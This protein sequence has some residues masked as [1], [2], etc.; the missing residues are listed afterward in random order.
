MHICHEKGFVGGSNVQRQ[1]VGDQSPGREPNHGRRI[2][3]EKPLS[4][5]ILP[6]LALASHAIRQISRGYFD[7]NVESR[8]QESDMEI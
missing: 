2:S 4:H 5:S 1:N 8:V 3:S 7:D 6:F